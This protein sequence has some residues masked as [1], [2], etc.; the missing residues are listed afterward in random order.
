M[1]DVSCGALGVG[2]GFPLAA[3]LPRAS[4]GIP[5]RSSHGTDTQKWL[6]DSLMDLVV[7]DFFSDSQV[8]QWKNLV[9]VN[10]SIYLPVSSL[11]FHL[12]YFTMYAPKVKGNCLG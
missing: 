4:V 11:K 3:S 9:L 10:L 2:F 1:A 12:G 8:V 6:M 7:A 5:P